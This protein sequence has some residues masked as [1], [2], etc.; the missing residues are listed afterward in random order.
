MTS[1]NEPPQSP[2]GGYAQSASRDPERVIAIPY[3]RAIATI[4]RLI[5]Q[6]T[7]ATPQELGD[8]YFL[9]TTRSGDLVRELTLR[10]ER[11]GPDTRVAVRVETISKTWLVSLF[12]L[13]CVM[14]LGI[15][16]LIM[17]PWIQARRRRDGRERD[18][19]THKMFRAIEDVVA[20]DGN[21]ATRIPLDEQVPVVRVMSSSALGIE[22][23]EAANT[24]SESESESDPERRRQRTSVR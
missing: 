11:Q 18:V 23:T 22:A 13:F 1:V 4:P 3:E 9:A 10:L 20:A 2:F 15:G 12:I 7:N 8:G 6:V 24:E 16:A 5:S 21:N 14:T 17:I 19:V